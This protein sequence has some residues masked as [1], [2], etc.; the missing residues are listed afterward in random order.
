MISRDQY[1]RLINPAN[2]A[3]GMSLEEFEEWTL[4][5]RGEIMY[6]QSLKD[7]LKAFEK[8]E[9]FEH[10][11]ILKNRILEEENKKL[12]SNTGKKDKR[13]LS[14]KVETIFPYL[15]AMSVFLIVLKLSNKIDLEWVFVLSPVWLPGIALTV[16]YSIVFGK[17][18]K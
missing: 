13:S 1:R 11:I 9:M 4:I 6:L 10:C 12:I 5:G 17:I 3:R 2:I 15:P 14:E 16:F 8:E 18:K 7:A